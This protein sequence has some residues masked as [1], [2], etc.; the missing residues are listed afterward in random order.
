LGLVLIAIQD[1]NMGG[2]IKDI[3]EKYAQG[4]IKVMLRDVVDWHLEN[5]DYW[6]AIDEIKKYANVADQ[7]IQKIIVNLIKQKKENLEDPNLHNYSD[8][9]RMKFKLYLTTNY[10]NLL[11]EHIKCDNVPIL[12]KELDFSTQDMFDDKRICH[13]HGF[14]SNPGLIVISRSSYNALYSNEKYGEL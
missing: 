5:N 7:D 3:T 13:L 9:E 12:L 8:L 11:Y 6:G 1:T 14:K 4:K 10:E 2:L